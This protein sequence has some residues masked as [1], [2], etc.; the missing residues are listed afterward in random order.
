MDC[1]PIKC[2]YIIIIFHTVTSYCIVLYCIQWRI[3]EFGS[4]GQIS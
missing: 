2:D 3:Q 1:G 4:G